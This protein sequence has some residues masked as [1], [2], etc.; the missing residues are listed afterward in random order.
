M[1]KKEILNKLSQLSLDKNKFIIGGESALV[2]LGYKRNTSIITF[3]S[4]FQ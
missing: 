3:S 1:N 4:N 2:L